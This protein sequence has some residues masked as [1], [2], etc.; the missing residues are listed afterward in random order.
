M[1][2]NGDECTVLTVTLKNKLRMKIYFLHSHPL[3]SVSSAKC[4][5][6]TIDAKPLFINAL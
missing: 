6:V 5:G 2:L 1:L 4:L 3:V